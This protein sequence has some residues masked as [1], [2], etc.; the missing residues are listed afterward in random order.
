LA[1]SEDKSNW[2]NLIQARREEYAELQIVRP[3]VDRCIEYGALPRPKE[4]GGYSVIWEDLF[5]QSDK[6]LAEVGRTRAEAL[7]AYTSTPTAEDVVPPESFY[8][9]FLGLDAD[10]IEQIRL[11]REASMKEEAKAFGESEEE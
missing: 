9:Y 5:A 7:R 1:S 2:L 3:F 6:E 11:I 8:R 10:Q 4:E